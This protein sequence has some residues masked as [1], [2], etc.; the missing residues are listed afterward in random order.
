MTSS[1]RHGHASSAA[2][3]TGWPTEEVATGW[4]TKDSLCLTL[5][6]LNWG[7]VFF[8]KGETMRKTR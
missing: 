5:I 1:L 8:F 3:S 4:P 7:G 2:A 6:C